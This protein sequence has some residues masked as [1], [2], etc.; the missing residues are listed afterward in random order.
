ML[1]ERRHID[2]CALNLKEDRVLPLKMQSMDKLYKG[3]RCLS[4]CRCRTGTGGAQGG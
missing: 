2:I 4:S 3:E 1:R